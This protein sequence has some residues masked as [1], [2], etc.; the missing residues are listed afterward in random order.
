MS[1]VR[2]A[3]CARNVGF[4]AQILPIVQGVIS[5]QQ[6]MVVNQKR[7]RKMLNINSLKQL[8]DKCSRNKLRLVFI[9]GVLIFSLVCRVLGCT[10]IIIIFLNLPHELLSRLLRLIFG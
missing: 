6:Y 3:V 2:W 8:H 7:A 10:H 1:G 9:F 4:N 5:P